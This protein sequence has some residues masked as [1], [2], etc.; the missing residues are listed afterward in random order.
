[1]NRRLNRRTGL[2][3]SALVVTAGLA[4]T[5]GVSA[6]FLAAPMSRTWVLA[7]APH[8]ALVDETAVVA[9]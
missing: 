7:P 5:A 8:G 4:V 6:R 9:E 2:L 3:V 1:M